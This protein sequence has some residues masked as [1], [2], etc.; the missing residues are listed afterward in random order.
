MIIFTPILYLANVLHAFFKEF[1]NIL[2]VKTSHD[3]F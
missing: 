2:H 1:L 3:N